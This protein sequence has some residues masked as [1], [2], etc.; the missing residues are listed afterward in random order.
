M[1]VLYVYIVYAKFFDDTVTR[2]CMNELRMC[3]Q[4][5]LVSGKSGAHEHKH[6]E[7]GAEPDHLGA[8]FLG[9]VGALGIFAFLLLNRLSEFFHIFKHAGDTSV[10]APNMELECIDQQHHHHHSHPNPPDEPAAAATAAGV[11]A[12]GF[13]NPLLQQHAHSDR[14]VRMREPKLPTIT[15]E[16]IIAAA[17]DGPNAGH[18]TASGVGGKQLQPL[19][20]NGSL[21][22][23]EGEASASLSPPS[24][25]FDADSAKQLISSSEAGGAS[26][27]ED[28]PAKRG[29]SVSVSVPAGIALQSSSHMHMPHHPEHH[30]AAV[31]QGVGPDGNPSVLK[32]KRTLTCSGLNDEDHCEAEQQSTRRQHALT[33]CS[34]D[35][36]NQLP[37]SLSS[38]A[39]KPLA[40]D[41]E[42]RMCPRSLSA[43]QPTI[44]SPGHSTNA[45]KQPADESVRLRAN[46]QADS[47]DARRADGYEAVAVSAPASRAAP[48]PTGAGVLVGVDGGV[49]VGGESEQQHYVDMVGTGHG[50][51]L[52]Q[53]H[54]VHH[55]HTHE[56][57]AHGHSHGGALHDPSTATW[58]SLVWT[59]LVGDGMH[60]LCD[61]LAIGSQFMI[62]PWGGFS[63]SVAIFFH[64]I[65]HEI[66]EYARLLCI[67]SSCVN[68]NTCTVY[69]ISILYCIC[70]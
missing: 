11:T 63:T 14:E 65:P 32:V 33:F 28:S 18:T 43:S 29:C 21:V 51:A 42:Q 38:A 66:G 49:G 31:F 61:G 27:S 36:L 12:N 23:A 30:T 55:H 54:H 1:S 68:A 60:N 16:R 5:M 9:L 19:E 13:T 45:K 50:Q 17:V 26:A 46:G 6:E 15:S 53:S 8:I 7:G 67:C 69:C 2:V 35:A 34:H 44:A 40:L 4:A 52:R 41:V 47:G 70:A 20:R 37:K 39:E 58:S 57:A 24:A 25:G 48:T 64:E 56:A 62:N 59:V 3:V 22:P 10:P